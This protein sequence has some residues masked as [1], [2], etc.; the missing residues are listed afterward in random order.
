MNTQDDLPGVPPT[1]I[2]IPASKKVGMLLHTG[3]QMALT[4]LK[5]ELEDARRQHPSAPGITMAI[6]FTERRLAEATLATTRIVLG[7]AAKAGMPIENHAIATQIVDDELV[8]TAEP[9]DGA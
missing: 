4:G 1:R 9:G 7:E 5:K 8:I 6:A 2:I 3:E